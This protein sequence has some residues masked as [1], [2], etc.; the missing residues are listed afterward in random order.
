MTSMQKPPC[1]C[2][3]WHRIR[4]STPGGRTAPVPGGLIIVLCLVVAALAAIP[5]SPAA[6]TGTHPPTRFGIPPG[7]TLITRTTDLRTGESTSDT[8]WITYIGSE[9]P[10]CYVAR[11]SGS[12]LTT[13]IRM[14]EATLLPSRYQLVASDGH[15]ER[16][17][18]FSEKALRITGNDEGEAGVIETGGTTHT[19]AT[20]LQ[21]LRVLAGRPA[22]ART[23][24]R[25]LVVRGHGKYRVVG[26]YARRTGEEDISVPAGSFRC[27]R[28]EF[29]IAGV[30]G[31]LFWRTRYHYY[32]TLAAPH[33]FVKY[34]DPDGEKIELVEYGCADTP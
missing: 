7:E 22:P 12:G 24:F 18:E 1:R 33:H 13:V 4:R 30:I 6:D 9:D 3:A 21:Y 15:M 20:L 2:A 10:P 31:R 29:G 17:I 23:D 19:G 8:T 16:Q 5:G 26:A 25:L 28:I 27:V 32:Y 14:N 34:V 11:R